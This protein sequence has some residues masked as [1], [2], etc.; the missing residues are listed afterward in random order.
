MLRRKKQSS[1]LK[2]CSGGFV[3]AEFAIALPLLIFLGWGLASVGSEIFYLGKIQLA[4]YVLEAEAQYVMERITCEARAAKKVYI[5]R[6][7]DKIDEIKL[8]YHTITDSRVENENFVLTLVDVLETQYFIPHFEEN[9]CVNI[10]AKRKEAGALGNPITGSNYF[11]DTKI[12][13]MRFEKDGK[14]LHITLEMESLVTGHK[15]KLDTAVFM[16]ACEN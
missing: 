13:Q 8:L 15:I 1:L 12:N 4:D 10:N 2:V 5:V 14:I 3:F 16:S 11:G 9:V 7:T 6:Y